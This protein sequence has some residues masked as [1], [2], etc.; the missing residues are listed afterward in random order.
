MTGEI[1]KQIIQQLL[2]MCYMKKKWSFVLPTFQ[3]TI[4]IVKNQLFFWHC[5]VVKK[6]STLLKGIT[7][8]H[9]G[10]FYC[11][12]CLHSFRIENNLKSHEKVCNNK[13]FY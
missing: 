2:L 7:S 12:N 8:K 3:N 1:S 9:D 10:I 13:D 5:L 6:L 11:F 4:Q